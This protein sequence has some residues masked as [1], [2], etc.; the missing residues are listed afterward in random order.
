MFLLRTRTLRRGGALGAACIRAATRLYVRS[1]GW[2]SGALRPWTQRRGDRVSGTSS[3][4]VTRP[5][6]VGIL[7]C[8]YARAGRVEDAR[9]LVGELEE[10]GG[11]GEYIP[12]F[13]AL[14]IFV[15]LG[16]LAGIR[17]ALSK[18]IEEATAAFTISAICGHFL[19]TFRTDPEI[20]R[21]HVELFD[22]RRP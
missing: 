18:V 19:E 12:A 22:S 11:R 1:V 4:P 15:G 10:R 14:A 13:A 3:A 16:D 9:R 21:L 5:F 8:A 17:G 2:R 20:D 6:F 7:G